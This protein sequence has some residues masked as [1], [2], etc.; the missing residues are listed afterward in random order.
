MQN[1]RKEKSVCILTSVHTPFDTR[2]FHK[3]AKTLAKVGYKVTLVAQHDKNEVFDGVKIIALPKPRNRI[4]RMFGLTSRAFSLA[5]RQRADVYH[6]HDPELLPVG[7]LLKFSTRSKVIYDVH[8]N[9]PNQILNKTWLHPW[10]R[11]LLPVFYILVERACLP[12]VD[13]IVLAEDSYIENYLG[14]K[15]VIP[16]RNY[17]LLSYVTP[18]GRPLSSTSKVSGNVFKVIYIGGITI[19]RGSMELIE[20]LRIMKDEGHKK[21]KLDLVGPVVTGLQTKLDALIQRHELQ[22]NV[23]ICNSVPHEKVFELLAQAHVGVAVLRPN[24]NYVASLPTKLFEYMA[25]GLP[26]IA[27][28]FPLWKEIVEGNNCGLTVDPLNPEDI[29]R[30][31]KYLLE[32]PDEARQM[33]ENGKKAVLEKYNWENESKKLL[34]L[35]EELLKR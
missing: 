31:M 28:N 10:L 23:F 13:R 24:P 34:V 4:V 19:L 33:G 22:D 35:Y 18:H 21:A 12:F 8:E 32:H 6:F 3:Q 30:A 14:R 15:N 16:I 27:S 11:R 1:L 26:V 9:V 29:A 17:T 20:A 7:V 2:I 5:L 25:V